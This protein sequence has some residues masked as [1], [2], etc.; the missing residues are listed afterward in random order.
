MQMLSVLLEGF[1]EDEPY[2]NFDYNN[3]FVS[4]LKLLRGCTDDWFSHLR[5]GQFKKACK[6]TY[7][8]EVVD[9]VL[10]EA[11]AAETRN[12]DTSQTTL[13]QT[14][15]MMSTFIEKEGDT[16]HRRSEHLSS[17]HIPEELK[18]AA[19]YSD[20]K[21]EDPA[22]WSSAGIKFGGESFLQQLEVEQTT[23][24]EQEIRIM[25][26]GRQYCEKLLQ[27]GCG[28]SEV[29]ERVQHKLRGDFRA[30]RAMKT[31]DVTVV[32]GEPFIHARPFTVTEL[33]QLVDEIPPDQVKSMLDAGITLD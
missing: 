2:F 29:A 14:G 3:F 24:T 33:K 10:W 1:T 30:I 9:K 15:Q 5:I 18:P 8:Y 22:I 16:F 13:Y 25:C 27:I 7:M 20:Q 21:R 12:I 4:C 32:D 11:V 28:D 23:S 19:K 6:R 17:G 31:V 26:G